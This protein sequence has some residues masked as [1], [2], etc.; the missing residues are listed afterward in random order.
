MAG[1]STVSV[2]LLPSL[3]P[4]SGLAG[5][6][7]VVVDVLRATTVIVRALAAGCNAVF[8]CSEIQEAQRLHDSMAPE[9]A[10][11]AGERD[12]LPIPGF[13]LGNSPREFVPEVCVGK[14]LIMTTSN[15]T[16]AILA[17]QEA[18]RVLV[19]SFANLGATSH[20]LRTEQRPI[21]VVCA[22]TEGG[23]SLE[24]S[25]LAGALVWEL[26]LSSPAWRLKPIEPANDEAEIVLGLWKGLLNE[27]DNGHSLEELLARG[28]GG[29][30]VQQLGLQ[31]DIHDAAMMDSLNR[32]CELRRDPLRIV[33]VK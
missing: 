21:H 10:L 22:G 18:D 24:D 26:N 9:T 7:V 6:V 23:L 11:L 17:C 15:G 29:R 8:P 33:Q 14:S 1:L 5:R 30:R 19:A 3:I 2:H 16:R 27:I 20:M 25:I 4:A 31:P 12:G 13:T 28:R 32:I